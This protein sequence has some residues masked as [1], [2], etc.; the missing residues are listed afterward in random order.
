MSG[1][2]DRLNFNFESSKF[3][4]AVYL[5]PSANAF[6]NIAPLAISSWAQSDLANGS[7][8]LSNYFLNPLEDVCS[9]LTSNSTSIQTTINNIIN[10][11]GFSVAPAAAN[12]CA[13]AA[14]NLI[15]QISQFKSHTDNVSGARAMTSNNDIIP[16]LESATSIGNYLL[17]IVNTTDSVSNTVPLLGNMT[18]LFIKDDLIANSTTI[19]GYPATITSTSTAA[20]L[21]II[22]DTLNTVNNY[23]YTTRTNDWNFYSTSSVIIKEYLTLNKIENMG[24]TQKYLANTL[25]GTDRLK[26]NL[27]NT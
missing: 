12:N 9:Y 2:F 24:G 22:T 6:L 23:I 18:A 4:D 25:I 7:V 14:A 8:A 10:T 27:A 19:S 13:N 26:E 15:V 1:V 5:T 3:G 17:R 21:N 11:T 16:S 20:E